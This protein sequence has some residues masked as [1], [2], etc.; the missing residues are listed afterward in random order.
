MKKGKSDSRNMNKS[1]QIK[2][3][4]KSLVLDNFVEH[5][6]LM[7]HVH[8]MN[9]FL[10]SIYPVFSIFRVLPVIVFCDRGIIST[11]SIPEYCL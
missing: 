8:K 5:C 4:S 2:F 9:T 3:I 7:I 1:L 10:F 6:N 11:V